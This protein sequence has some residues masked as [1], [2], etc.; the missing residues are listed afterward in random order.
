MERNAIQPPAM[1]VICH[2]G[3][4]VSS[5]CKAR[6]MVVLLL[7]AICAVLRTAGRHVVLLVLAL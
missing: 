5:C 3:N 7:E 6:F 4:L 2:P 1:S